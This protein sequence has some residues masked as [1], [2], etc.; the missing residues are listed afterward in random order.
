MS[1]QC[2]VDIQCPLMDNDDGH[3]MDIK[4]MY[5]EWTLKNGH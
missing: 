1:I 4:Q 3:P 2:S 5:T